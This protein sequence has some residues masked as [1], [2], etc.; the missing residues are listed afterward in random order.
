MMHGLALVAELACVRHRE[1]LILK[2]L[3][4]LRTDIERVII[5][6]GFV[7][8]FFLSGAPHSLP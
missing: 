5:H 3:R 4:T 7:H 8:L 2:D 6:L 1:D